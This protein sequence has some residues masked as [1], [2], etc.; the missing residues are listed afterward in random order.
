[1]QLSPQ[2]APIPLELN[3]DRKEGSRQPADV[4]YQMVTIVA[5][6]LLLGTLCAF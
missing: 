6:L 5:M 3:A 1:M 2:S 4:A